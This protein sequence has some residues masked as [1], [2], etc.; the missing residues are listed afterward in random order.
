VPSLEEAQAILAAL[1]SY[2]NLPAYISFTCRDEVHTSHGETLKSC[3]SFLDTQ[4]AIIGVGVNCTRPEYIGS[5]I[6]E[7]ASVTKKTII[8]YPNSGEGWNAEQHCWIGDGQMQEYG[9]LAREWRA[10]GARWIGGCCRT[11]PEHIRAAAEALALEPQ[12][13]L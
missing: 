12:K 10:A 5:L 6:R 9:Q 7:I 4:P 13:M 8:V 3:A 2:P 1:E 11:G